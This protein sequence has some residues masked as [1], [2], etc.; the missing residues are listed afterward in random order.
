MANASLRLNHEVYEV[1][2][3]DNGD[4]IIIDLMDIEFPLK[5]QK[6]YESIQRMQGEMEQAKKLMMKKTDTPQDGLL[7]KNEKEVLIMM[8]EKYKEMRGVLDDLL[9]EGASMKIFGK[10]NYWTMFNDFFDAFG[11]IME[12]AGLNMQKTFKAIEEKYGEADEKAL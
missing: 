10:Y 1:E 8:R 4:T 3:N 12:Q 9:G 6:A 5:F 2:V 11:P 7:S